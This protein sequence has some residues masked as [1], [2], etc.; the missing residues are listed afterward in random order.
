MFS[1]FDE[2]VLPQPA[3]LSARLSD[4]QLRVYET[5]ATHGPLTDYE[6]GYAYRLTH[7]DLDQSWSGLRTRRKELVD[8]GVLYLQARR[9][10]ENG[11]TVGVYAL[12]Y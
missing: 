8:L 5:F 1:I 7:G 9:K 12:T 10:N 2:V 4:S 11:R 6:L 3:H